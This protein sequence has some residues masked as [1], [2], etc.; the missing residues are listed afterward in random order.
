MY[1]FVRF[2]L[3]DNG[4]WKPYLSRCKLTLSD[5][6]YIYRGSRVSFDL[7]G[8]VENAH[9]RGD[10]SSIIYFL[11]INMVINSRLIFIASE[12]RASNFFFPW[13]QT[14]LRSNQRNPNS[15]IRTRPSEIPKM[16][17]PGGPSLDP[18][19]HRSRGWLSASSQAYNLFDLDF[20]RVSAAQ[21]ARRERKREKRIYI[22]GERNL[23][24]QQ[25]GSVQLLPR[26]FA[27]F[28]HFF[29]CPQASSGCNFGEAPDLLFA[30]E[31]E[32]RREI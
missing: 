28:L 13:R 18:L 31:N 20:V 29:F 21:R 25:R 14:I 32:T 17:Q 4:Q 7:C 11:L 15:L 30:S 9:S 10:E 2:A 19:H 5:I 27:L 12:D 16:T 22:S 3:A 6:I 24:Q 8:I 1:L 23:Q 26:V